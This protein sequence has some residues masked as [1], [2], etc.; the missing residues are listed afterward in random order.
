MSL[1][2]HN[3]IAVRNVFRERKHRQNDQTGPQ[4][5]LH[6]TPCKYLGAYLKYFKVQNHVQTACESPDL[7]MDFRL[8]D[9]GLKQLYE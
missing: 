6:I 2:R 7:N 1:R 8:F 5:F 4:R 3:V 9:N